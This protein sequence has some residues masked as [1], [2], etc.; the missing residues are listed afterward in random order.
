MPRSSASV[1]MIPITKQPV[2]FTTKVP[3]GRVDP[4]WSWTRSETW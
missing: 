1:A 3:H 2:T 4:N